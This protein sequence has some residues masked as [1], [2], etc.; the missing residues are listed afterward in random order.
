MKLDTNAGNTVELTAGQLYSNT[1][2]VLAAPAMRLDQLAA[3]VGTTPNTI[4]MRLHRGQ[5]LNGQPRYT[6][7]RANYFT[8]FDLVAIDAVESLASQGVPIGPTHAMVEEAARLRLQTCTTSTSIRDG[9]ALFVHRSRDTGEWT[10]HE[11]YEGD[12]LPEHL[13]GATLAMSDRRLRYRAAQFVAIY[14]SAAAAI[15]AANTTTRK[16]SNG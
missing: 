10:A 15:R 2:S 4:T 5:L 12:T 7:G 16:E 8:C 13:T 1:F 6:R 3:L 14:Q 9:W 11:L